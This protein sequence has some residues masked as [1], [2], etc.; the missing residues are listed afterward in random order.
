MRKF[1]YHDL[2][3]GLLFFFVGVDLGHWKIEPPEASQPTRQPNY[4]DRSPQT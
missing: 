1:S 4:T 2:T 3:M